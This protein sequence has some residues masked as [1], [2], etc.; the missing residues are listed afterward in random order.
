[1]Y[2]TPARASFQILGPGGESVV[3]PASPTPAVA[4]DAGTSGIIALTAIL[5]VLGLAL[6]GAGFGAFVKQMRGREEQVTA[7][8]RRD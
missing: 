8:V 6:F 2:G 1:M 7:P 5:G 3:Q 4:A